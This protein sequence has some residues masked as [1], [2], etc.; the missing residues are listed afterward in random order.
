MSRSDEVV[1]RHAHLF[2]YHEC[3]NLSRKKAY[4]KAHQGRFI[5]CIQKNGYVRIAVRDNGKIKPLLAHRLIFYM[6]HGYLPSL[7]DHINRNPSDNRIENLREATVSENHRNRDMR[8][9]NKYHGVRKTPNGK[10]SFTLNVGTFDSEDVA[11]VAY[12]LVIKRLGLDDFYPLNGELVKGSIMEK[13]SK[14]SF[15]D[16]ISL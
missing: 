14:M 12:D 8:K 10:Y 15:D 4:H 1:K 11:A 3:G 9:T 16:I 6:H 2:K 13:C 7:I 5:G